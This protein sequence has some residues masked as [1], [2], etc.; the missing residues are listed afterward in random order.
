MGR[1]IKKM[2]IKVLLLIFFYILLFSCGGLEETEDPDRRRDEPVGEPK[3]LDL[4]VLEFTNWRDFL[5]NCKPDLNTPDNLTD[6]IAG[7]VPGLNDYYLPGL[8]RACFKKKSQE[9]HDQICEA[10]DHWERI[11]K[12]PK[13]SAQKARAENELDKLARIEDRLNDRLY[14]F[15]DRARVR[16]QKIR[17]KDPHT[18]VGR[19]IKAWG[20]DE[21]SG[22]ETVLDVESYSTCTT[23]RDDDDDDD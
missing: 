13:S 19:F 18:W 21:V 10:R 8:F 7:A 14:K 22:W 17:N 2:K 3:P 15:G 9:A 23:Y 4:D 20:E 1:L 12:N 16:M 11:K 6:I 5:K